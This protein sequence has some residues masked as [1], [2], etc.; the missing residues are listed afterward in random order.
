MVQVFVHHIAVIEEED[1]QKHK[2][3]TRFNQILSNLPTLL[4]STFS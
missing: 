3:N 2:Q 4:P 1:K